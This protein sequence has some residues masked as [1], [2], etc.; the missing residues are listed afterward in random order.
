M[1]V[2]GKNAPL[3]ALWD[4]GR[5][6]SM[7]LMTD[8]KLVLGVHRARGTGRR[9]GTYDR[10]WGNAL[11]WLVRDPDLTTLKVTADPP[12]VEPG[13]PGGRGG[14]RR[15]CRTTSRRRTR[16]CG[17][18]CSRWRRR[19]RWPSQTGTTGAGRGGAAG[20]RAAGAGAVQAARAAKKGETDLGEGRGRGGGARGGPGAVGRV[21]AAG[22]ARADRQGHRRQGVHAAARTRCPTCRCW[23]RRVVEV[24]RAKDQPLW[25]R[26][27]YLVAARRRCWAP[28]GSHGGGSGTCESA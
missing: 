17:W 10:F 12:S 18:S 25:D 8:A 23:I 11:R 4:Y 5:G 13:K 19:S 3:V 28:S 27:Y 14:A 26:W 24:G 6:R 21:G 20:V 15:G 22:A 7:A 2:D 16:R 1:T 9:T